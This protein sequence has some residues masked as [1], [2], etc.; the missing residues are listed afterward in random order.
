MP[1]APAKDASKDQKLKYLEDLEESLKRTKEQ[2]KM[3][4]VKEEAKAK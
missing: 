1:V 2:V 3:E 4:K